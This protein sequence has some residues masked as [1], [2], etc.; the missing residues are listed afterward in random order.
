MAC[1]MTGH[2]V[3]AVLR[4]MLPSSDVHTCRTSLIGGVV[5]R[6]DNVLQARDL[7]YR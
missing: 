4:A 5:K 1:T 3:M 6:S 2:R 7:A